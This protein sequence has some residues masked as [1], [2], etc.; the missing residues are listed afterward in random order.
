MSGGQLQKK[1][2]PKLVLKPERNDGGPMERVQGKEEVEGDSKGVGFVSR[3]MA[4][5]I[6][7]TR[8]SA[9]SERR[10]T[11][12]DRPTRVENRRPMLRTW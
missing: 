4:G 2:E 5:G 9:R 7:T 1:L 3:E 6:S 10:G 8:K 11:V 12:V